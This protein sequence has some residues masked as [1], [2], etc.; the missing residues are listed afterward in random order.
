MLKIDSSDRA[1]G[2]WLNQYYKKQ[3]YSITFYLRKISPA[4]LNNNINN[5]KLLA[6]INT[7]EQ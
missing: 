7:F 3:L 2:A 4:K 5:K 1:V 6:V